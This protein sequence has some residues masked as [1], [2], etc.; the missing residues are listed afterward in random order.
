MGGVAMTNTLLYMN[1]TD[2]VRGRVMTMYMLDDGLTPLSALF[3]GTVA[4]IFCAP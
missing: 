2:Y 1:I 3:V 4:S